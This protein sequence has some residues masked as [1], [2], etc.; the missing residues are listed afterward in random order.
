MALRNVPHSA[1]GVCPYHLLLGREARTPDADILTYLTKLYEDLEEMEQIVEQR[2]A[3]AKERSKSY[4]D[5]S[6]AEDP[7]QVDDEVLCMLPTGESG[8]TAKWEGPYKVL[9]VLGPL[10]YLINKPTKGRKGRRVHR[11]ALKRYM[12]HVSLA[13]VITAQDDN[14]KIDNYKLG[15]EIPDRG[16]QYS[17][18]DWERAVQVSGLSL[19]QQD[20]LRSLLHKHETVFSDL[21]GDADMPAFSIE[22]GDARPTAAKPYAVPQAYWEKTKEELKN[23]QELGIIEDST[24]PWSSPVICVPKPEGGLRLCMDYRKLN[25]VTSTDVY[26]LPNIEHLVQKIST[27]KFITTMD[28]TKGY[29]QI[30]LDPCSKEKTAFV[31]PFGKWQFRKM[32]FGV[33]NAP[34]WFQRHM[35]YLLRGQ[36]NADA[37]IDDVCI[38]SNTWTE[39]LEHL[40]EALVTLQKARLTVKLSKCSFARSEV[41]YLGH[42]VGGG[43]IVPVDAKVQ[44][45]AAMDKPITKKG[46]RRF[47][48]MAS[49]YRRFIPRYADLAADL[50]TATSKKT[51]NTI[52]WISQRVK[53]FN[54]VQEAITRTVTLRSPDQSLPYILKTDASGKG[55]GA[56]LEQ[57]KDGVT[58]PIAF[59]SR[60]LTPTESRYAATELETLA[61]IEAVKHF[62]IYL[63]GTRFQVET[64]HRALEFIKT[65]K[66]GSPKL[67]RW[68]A[69]LQEYDCSITY[70]PGE[71]NQVADALSRAYEEDDGSQRAPGA[72]QTL[73]PGPAK[74]PLVGGDVGDPPDMHQDMAPH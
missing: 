60:K 56:A 39:H 46:L 20:N 36:E 13:H 9:E 58:Y 73:Q 17:M 44:A 57:E 16:K 7:L 37:Y 22:T 27:A 50:H 33:K 52:K 70:R 47:L 24:S 40:D 64:D 65:M 49:Y 55:V 66:R 67:M 1:L 62:D 42:R 6:A 31:T 21:P 8:L 4:Y 69:L 41:Q 10:T 26:P 43:K 30:P 35:D 14:V 32:P 61:I 54:Q 34:S 5:K 25:A 48:G 38:Y 53:A 72:E 11:N 28:L 45:I 12:Y 15:P 68:A 3:K 71:N 18:E 2:D 51:G 19:K 23:M 29:Y 63:R 59:Y 74:S